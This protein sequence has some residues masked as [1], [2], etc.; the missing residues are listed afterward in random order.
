MTT[1]IYKCPVC[2]T[3]TEIR[4]RM[5]DESTRTCAV[6][7]SVMHRVP[8]TFRVNW[9]GRPPSEGELS[10]EVRYLLDTKEKRR[11]EYERKLSERKDR[12]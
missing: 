5:T 1:Y 7:G 9:N 2:E 11:D 10:G 6:C 8:Q 4:H 3:T 12:I